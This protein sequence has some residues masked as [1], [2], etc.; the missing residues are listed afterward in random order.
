MER[1]PISKL[2]CSLLYFRIS[3]NGQVQ[4]PSNPKCY[5]RL[6][7]PFRISSVI[8]VFIFLVVILERLDKDLDLKLLANP[9]ERVKVST[10]QQSK[11]LR[12]RQRNGRKAHVKNRRRKKKILISKRGRKL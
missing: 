1:D 3:Y 11:I 6:S 7:E 9:Q 4:K 5:T 10:I 8:N 12:K 2:L